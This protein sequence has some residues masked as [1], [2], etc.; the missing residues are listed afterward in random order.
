MHEALKETL[1]RT[2]AEDI[3]VESRMEGEQ[4]QQSCEELRK[5]VHALQKRVFQLKKRKRD[6]LQHT[7]ESVSPA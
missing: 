7:N 5:K 6:H 2:V 4:V 3:E 1:P